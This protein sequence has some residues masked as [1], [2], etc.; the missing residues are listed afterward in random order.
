M[1][2]RQIIM[3]IVWLAIFGLVVLLAARVL[4][5]TGKKA[6]ATL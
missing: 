6:A 3:T 2:P 4:S 1:N 5:A